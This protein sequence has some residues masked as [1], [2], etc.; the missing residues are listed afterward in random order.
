MKEFD[1]LG[2]CTS[3]NVECCH[4]TDKTIPENDCIKPGVEKSDTNSY[5]RRP[6]E[7]RLF[8]FD[9]KEIYEKLTWV[10]WNNCHATPRLN[11]E[12]FMNFFEKNFSRTTSLE[13]I[14]SY[15]TRRKLDESRKSPTGRYIIIR[16]ISWPKT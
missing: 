3:C 13:D 14:K 2:Y 15:V 16:E 1:W 12:N 11:Y 6:L 7:C 8:P 4:N 10:M 5:D 9:V